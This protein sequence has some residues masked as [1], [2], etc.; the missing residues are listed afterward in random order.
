M[1][2]EKDALVWTE[3]HSAC[4]LFFLRRSFID[5]FLYKTEMKG[6]VVKLL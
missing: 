6:P 1:I 3:W 2:I 5:F 4:P